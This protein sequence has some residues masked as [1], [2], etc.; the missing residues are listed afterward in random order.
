MRLLIHH[1][2]HDFIPLKAFRA[3]HAL[4]DSFSV[5]YFEPK[6]FGGLATIEHASAELKHLREHL[7]TLIPQRLTTIELL[8]ATDGLQH[9]FEQALRQSNATIGL[10]EPEIAFAVAGFGDGLRA[11]CFAL[12]RAQTI[13]NSPHPIFAAVYQE[14]FGQ[15]GRLSSQ[16][17]EYE[18]QGAGWRV[19][20]VNH[21]YGRAGL[22][23]QTPHATYYVQDSIYTCPAESYM[24]NLLSEVAQA[25]QQSLV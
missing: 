8:R 23:V 19:Q 1:Q 7:L 2:P 18:H 3:A 13:P 25:L 22:L 6:D 24:F 4:P 15:S 20:I 5:A 16:V 9:E 12:I 11:W 10:R 17:H 21:L 14:W